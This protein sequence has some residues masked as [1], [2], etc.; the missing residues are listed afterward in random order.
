MNNDKNC[1]H[2]TR[3]CYIANP[4]SSDYLIS[5]LE[6]L[7]KRW[8]TFIYLIW[9]FLWWNKAYELVNLIY[10]LYSKGLIRCIMWMKEFLFMLSF[11]F[12]PA[13]NS[14]MNSK[15]NNIKAEHRPADRYKKIWEYAYYELFNNYWWK[16]THASLIN[17]YI[18]DFWKINV[19]EQVT[20]LCDFLY[21]KCHIYDFDFNKNYLCA[22]WI[23]IFA[24]WA[25]AWDRIN[26]EYS[27]WEEYIR[28]LDYK[29][30]ELDY[31]ILNK[32]LFFSNSM[33]NFALSQ[34]QNSK[35]MFN[36]LK[37]LWNDYDS[38]NILFSP[39][40]FN[41]SMYENFN[42]AFIQLKEV[43]KDWR[44]KRLICWW[45]VNMRDDFHN[46]L[47]PYA[48]KYYPYLI[49]INRTWSPIPEEFDQTNANLN[50]GYLIIKRGDNNDNNRILEI[51]DYFWNSMKRS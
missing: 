29:A 13:C 33:K 7:E 19:N 25:L 22:W 11:W 36:P 41:D 18:N 8:D 50:F 24:S 5:Y 35:K 37:L 45:S 46:I 43:L 48:K 23:P 32:L 40:E 9:N 16:E 42:N 27:V 4:P 51:W 39:L 15:I 21:E 14:I 34:Y 12:H 2:I 6:A 47:K 26:G 17:W 49:R 31:F 10:K 30:K 20:K 1:P 38:Y 28:A 3:M 44:F